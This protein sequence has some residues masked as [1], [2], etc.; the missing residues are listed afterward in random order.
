MKK[1]TAYYYEIIRYIESNYQDVESSSFPNTIQIVE[2]ENFHLNQIEHKYSISL[3][4]YQ[5]KHIS[6]IID[7]VNIY[8]RFKTES[9]FIAP[10]TDIDY[11]G[12]LARYELYYNLDKLSKKVYVSCNRFWNY[13]NLSNPSFQIA[14]RFVRMAEHTRNRLDKQIK[15]FILEYKKKN[16]VFTYNKFCMYIL[17]KMREHFANE[18]RNYYFVLADLY[19]F[20]TKHLHSF[21]Y[22]YKSNRH[23]LYNTDS[24]SYYEFLDFY[25]NNEITSQDIFFVKPFVD[26]YTIG[27]KGIVKDKSVNLYKAFDKLLREK[28]VNPLSELDIL[29]IT[30]ILKIRYVP[31]TI[32]LDEWFATIKIPTKPRKKARKK[33]IYDNNIANSLL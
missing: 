33:T 11:I 12:L 31:I 9:S 15:N 7:A 26:Y 21:K 3:S 18:Y 10:K 14:D 29:E 32:P 13:S 4:K 22:Y 16:K 1:F 19:R 5:L 28:A 17:N 8:R 25:K 30:K 20:T 23:K 24:M 2:T 6:E 27:I